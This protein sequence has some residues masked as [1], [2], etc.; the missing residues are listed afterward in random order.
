MCKGNYLRMNIFPKSSN[1]GTKWPSGVRHQLF[2]LEKHI[3]GKILY[4]IN[5]L[6]FLL[7]LVF[8]WYFPPSAEHK[9][10]QPIIGPL[11]LHPRQ[12]VSRHDVF[13]HRDGVTLQYVICLV[14]LY[15]WNNFWDLKWHETSQYWSSCLLKY[16]IQYLS[17]RCI[18]GIDH[19]TVISG[20][21]Q[22]IEQDII[23][24]IFNTQGEGGVCCSFLDLGSFLWFMYSI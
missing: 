22:L 11:L 9:G 24:D 15:L 16:D 10:P 23:L 13:S 8:N 19:R 5:Y 14:M 3:W 12:L 1:Q 17:Y 6:N 21:H 4:S 7:S 20:R 18:C 2:K